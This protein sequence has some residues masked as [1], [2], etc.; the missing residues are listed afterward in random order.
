M[1]LWLTIVRPRCFFPL[2]SLLTRT[3]GGEDGHGRARLFVGCS[4][5]LDATLVTTMAS[6]P[7]Y[8]VLD[9]V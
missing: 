8:L 5:G 9:Q 7:V 2:S 3:R 4:C 6:S 1:F